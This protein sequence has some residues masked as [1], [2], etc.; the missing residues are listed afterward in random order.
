MIIESVASGDQICE[1]CGSQFHG[2]EVIFGVVVVEFGRDPYG[3]DPTTGDFDISTGTIANTWVCEHCF[4][5]ESVV[6]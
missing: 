5:K 2:G 4:I 6:V 1:D 3:L